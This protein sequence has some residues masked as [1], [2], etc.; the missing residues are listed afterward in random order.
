MGSYKI[1]PKNALFMYFVIQD[2]QPCNMRIARK[3]NV[4]DTGI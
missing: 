2:L 1:F 3:E 4:Q